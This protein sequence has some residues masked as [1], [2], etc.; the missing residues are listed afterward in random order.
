MPNYTFEDI[1]TGK[2]NTETMKMDELE[3]YLKANPNKR[4]IFTSMPGFV[5]SW[6]VGGASGKIVERK[7]GFKEVLNKI[8]KKTPGSRLSK[9]T[10]I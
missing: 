7:K 8:H 10:D 3:S 2:E 1:K 5:S 6:N 4:Q 9:T